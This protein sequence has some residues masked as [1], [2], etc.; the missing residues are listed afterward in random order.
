[1]S[2]YQHLFSS[3]AVLDVWRNRNRDIRNASRDPN[4][5]LLTFQYRPEDVRTNNKKYGKSDGVETASEDVGGAKGRGGS[6]AVAEGSRSI[7]FVVPWRS[8]QAQKR[9][10]KEKEKELAEALVTLIPSLTANP[11]IQIRHLAAGLSRQM[12]KV[13][14]QMADNAPFC[15]GKNLFTGGELIRKFLPPTE[16][17]F[18]QR[19][20]PQRMIFELLM[21]LKDLVYLGMTECDREVLEWELNNFSSLEDLDEVLVRS[22]TPVAFEEPPPPSP[23]LEIPIGG[24]S[25][26]P[27]L[28]NPQEILFHLESL[29]TTAAALSHLA[30]PVT[31]FCAKST[32][33][34]RRMLDRRTLNDFAQDKKKRADRCAEYAR[35]MKWA[36][37]SWRQGGGCRRGCKNEDEDPEALPC[38]HSSS[39][40]FDERGAYMV[41]GGR[42]EDKKKAGDILVV[43]G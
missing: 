6:S 5:L 36:G 14:L 33:T 38:W 13:E 34:L 10:L 25:S 35:C 37:T 29:E 1:M 32:I 21:E 23:P 9:E 8:M 31:D 41:G 40:F 12:S 15:T 3:K 42:P 26:Q 43:E 27:F 11:L 4:D 22:M 20:I 19:P 2:T 17:L 7:G 24:G 28:S 39:R 18:Q 30:I 16:A